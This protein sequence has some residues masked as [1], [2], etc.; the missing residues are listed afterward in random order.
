MFRLFFVCFLQFPRVRARRLAHSPFE[1]GAE[2]CLRRK[3]CGIGDLGEGHVCADEKLHGAVKPCLLYEFA[4]GLA[5]GAFKAIMEMNGAEGGVG[6]DLFQRE[7]GREVFLDEAN[8]PFDHFLVALPCFC[9]L[10]G[11][12]CRKEIEK[13]KK[14]A[15]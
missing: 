4:Q 10:F 9:R 11:Q 7:V 14:T 8:H 13:R 5:R 12:V 15:V 2:V 1:D 3:A 6:G